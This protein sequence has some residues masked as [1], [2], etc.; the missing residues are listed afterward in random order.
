VPPDVLSTVRVNSV[1]GAA[2]AGRQGSLPLV[3]LSPGF[4][5][6]RSVLTGLAEDH[7]GA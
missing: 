4:I 3:V 5:N 6:P 2:P 1:S 7:L